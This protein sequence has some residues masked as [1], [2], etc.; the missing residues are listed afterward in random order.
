MKGIYYAEPI[1]NDVG[2]NGSFIA[3]F[4]AG[5]TTYLSVAQPLEVMTFTEVRRPETPLQMALYKQ[6]SMGTII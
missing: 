5:Y 2:A 3:Q 4:L 6:A 1:A